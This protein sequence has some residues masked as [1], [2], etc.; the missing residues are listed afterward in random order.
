M[1]DCDIFKKIALEFGWFGQNNCCHRLWKIA[2]SAINRPIWSHWL[3]HFKNDSPAEE[4]ELEFFLHEM[5]QTRISQKVFGDR[6]NAQN[7]GHWGKVGRVRDGPSDSDI[8]QLKI[9]Y[10]MVYYNVD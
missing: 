10:S 2:Q 1:K 6:I 7:F 5:D 3:G 4:H 9:V 8:F